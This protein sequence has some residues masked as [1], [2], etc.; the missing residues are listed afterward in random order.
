[1]AKALGLDFTYLSQLETGRREVDEWY[2][3]KARELAEKIEKSKNVKGYPVETAD[4]VNLIGEIRQRCHLY[5]DRLLDA[6]EADGTPDLLVWLVV[7]L[8]RHFPIGPVKSPAAENPASRPFSSISPS[9]AEGSVA[10]AE[11]ALEM[12][13]RGLQPSSVAGAPSGHKCATSDDT[14]L[15]ATRK[16]TSPG[17]VPK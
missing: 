8:E 9:E 16:Q 2:V 10:A 14:S 3:M 1:M 12:E 5:V 17:R 15:G 7:E 13:G 11:K 4:A 6:Y